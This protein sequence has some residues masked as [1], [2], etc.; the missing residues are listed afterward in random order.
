VET[1]PVPAGAK[2]VRRNDLGA[3]RW[4]LVL[5]E[6][7][8]AGDAFQA[9]RG[10]AGDAYRAYEDGGHVCVKAEFAGVDPPATETMAAALGRWAALMPAASGAAVTRRGPTVE[11]TSCD[12]GAAAFPGGAVPGSQADE[13]MTLIVEA[14]GGGDQPAGAPG[15]SHAAPTT[16][17]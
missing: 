11:V 3:L 16:T 8:P 5:A 13:A 2:A 17:R 12:P 14:A 15:S 1:S 9:A 4:T 6:R 7:L 10:W